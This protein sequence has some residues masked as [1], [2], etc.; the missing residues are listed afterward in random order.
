MNEFL[1]GPQDIN[2]FIKFHNSHYICYCEVII[3]SNGYIEYCIPSHQSTLIR[4]SKLSR[5]ELENKISI[6]DDCLIKLCD[7]TNC[8]SVWYDF[9]VIPINV[10]QKQLNSL[11]LLK[12]AKCINPKIKLS[13]N[14]GYNNELEV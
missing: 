7:I 11:K 9:Y 12:E 4:T 13:S 2:T 1:K 14:Y 8:V 5:E 3:H 6:F 10:T